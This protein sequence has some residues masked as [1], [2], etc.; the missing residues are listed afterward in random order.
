[1]LRAPWIS[2]SQETLNLKRWKM[3]RAPWILPDQICSRSGNP[4]HVLNTLKL[5]SFI[6]M[7]VY[8]QKEYLISGDVPKKMYYNNLN[9]ILVDSKHPCFKK[10][11]SCRGLSVYAPTIVSVDW[12]HGFCFRPHRISGLKHGFYFRPHR[13]SGLKHGFCF[14]PLCFSGLRTWILFQTPSFQ[15]TENMTPSLSEGWEHVLCFWPQSFSEDWEHVLCSGPNL[16]RGLRTWTLFL[17][18]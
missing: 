4:V 9:W 6:N 14:R 17:A 13:F 8:D 16:F 12:E 11:P 15:W 3:L 10:L 7:D 1:M 18:P 5:G 2:D